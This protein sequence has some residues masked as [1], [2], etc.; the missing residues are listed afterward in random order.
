MPDYIWQKIQNAGENPEI[1]DTAAISSI[2]S[3]SQGN[4]RLIDN[5][6]TDAMTLGSQGIGVVTLAECL[7]EGGLLHQPNEAAFK[8]KSVPR[9][10]PYGRM[11]ECQGVDSVRADRISE[12]IYIGRNTVTKHSIHLWMMI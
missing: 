3:Y 4:P 6:M 10:Y 12:W 9:F 8:R 7:G 11:K 2:H 1:I 5:V